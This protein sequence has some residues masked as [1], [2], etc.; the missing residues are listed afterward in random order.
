VHPKGLD[1]R[2]AGTEFV[3][4]RSLFWL[5]WILLATGLLIPAPAGSFAGNAFG[6]SAFYVIGKAVVWSE[7]V[8]GD[9][10]SRQ[11]TPSGISCPQAHVDVLLLR[12]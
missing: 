11:N 1:G 6:I 5:A 12:E 3:S 7:A 8:P 10:V 4:R 2:R 9:G